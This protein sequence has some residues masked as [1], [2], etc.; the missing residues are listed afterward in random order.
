MHLSR[1]AQDPLDTFLRSFPAVDGEVAS[2]LRRNCCIGLW[3]Y[4][5]K[6]YHTGVENAAYGG[7]IGLINLIDLSFPF[8]LFHAYPGLRR[9]TTN[10]SDK[11]I[12]TP[13]CL[14]TTDLGYFT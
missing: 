12:I 13:Q 6:P 4:P 7:C 14:K 11:R 8:E 9:P 10:M 5:V 2:L 1:I 3:S